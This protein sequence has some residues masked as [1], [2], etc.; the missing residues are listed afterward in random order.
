[1]DKLEGFVML[2]KRNDVII[3]VASQIIDKNVQLEET[4]NGN[5]LVF[6][7]VSP[8]DEAVSFEDK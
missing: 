7:P 2:W 8:S 6:G 3:S 4:S 1:M 5:T